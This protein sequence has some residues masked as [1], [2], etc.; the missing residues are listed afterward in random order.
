MRAK[1]I[2]IL[3]LL[4]VVYLVFVFVDNDGPETNMKQDYSSESPSTESAQNLEKISLDR[5]LNSVPTGQ[6]PAQLRRW[7]QSK[8]TAQF[9]LQK[10]PGSERIMSVLGGKFPGV[11]S[12]VESAFD[13]LNEFSKQVGAPAKSLDKDSLFQTQT[14]RKRV[15]GFDQTYKGYKVFDSYARVHVDSRDDSAFMIMN[16]IK[17]INESVGLPEIAVDLGTASQ[18]ALDHFEGRYQSAEVRDHQLL[19]Y[20][21]NED[22][23]DLVWNLHLE[24]SSQSEFVL[25]SAV[26]GKIVANFP[27]QSHQ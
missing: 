7:L 2:S 6:D 21:I 19:V 22:R 5:E 12:T 25:V 16:N 1:W 18:S 8:A 11:G 9:K 10:E 26:D 23:I 20:S 17:P 14:T 24:G 13:F 27:A 15:I 4:I 3:L